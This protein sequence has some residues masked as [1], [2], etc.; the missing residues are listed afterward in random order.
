M[1]WSLMIEANDD[2]RYADEKEGASS[3]VFGFLQLQPSNQTRFGISKVAESRIPQT[4]QWD[5]RR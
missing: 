4:R 5:S 2:N 1:I 3:H